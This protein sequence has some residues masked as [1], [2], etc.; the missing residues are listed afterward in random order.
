MQAAWLSALGQSRYQ[1]IH[2]QT[3]KPTLASTLRVVPLPTQKEGDETILAADFYLP[4]GEVRQLWF[5][6]ESGQAVSEL[7]D[8]FLLGAIFIGLENAWG[9]HVEGKVSALLLQQLR[10]FQ[11]IW[12]AQAPALYHAAPLSADELVY[13]RNPA[14]ACI[15]TF[16]GGADSSFTALMHA[17]KS[18]KNSPYALQAGLMVQGLD[19]PL[20]DPAFVGA[21]ARSRE[22][23]ASLGLECLS[24]RTNFR[25]ISLTQWYHAFGSALAACLHV[26]SP[27]FGT[28][29]IPSSAAYHEPLNPAG[30]APLTDHL[31]GSD[32]LRIVHDGAIYARRDKLAA[33]AAWP[34]GLANLRVC[35]Q[36]Q[37]RDRNCCRCEKC[38]RNMINFRLL[39]ME[40]PN[41]FPEPLS[42]QL[43]RGLLFGK[44][45]ILIW[46]HLIAANTQGQLPADIV[47]AMRYARRRMQWRQRRQGLKRK[48]KQAWHQLHSR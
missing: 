20:D 26:L 21:L 24:I 8:P 27:R 10:E 9:I 35:W 4:T 5:A 29:L 11:A 18:G 13:T 42:P 34:Q 3:A 41:S 7:A 28:A 40:I 2:M 39:G 16:S 22:S 6:V 23:L 38:V 12:Q 46:G 14:Q 15:S 47:G 33:L 43:I 48:I 37:E 1:G 30:S 31:L 45:E 25:E 36:G 44:T 17:P 32:A 19:I